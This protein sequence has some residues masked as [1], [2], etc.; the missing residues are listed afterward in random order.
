[1]EIRINEKGSEAFYDESV[2][3]MLQYRKLLKNPEKKLQDVQKQLK[4]YVIVCAVFELL[5]L[6]TGFAWGFDTLT[7]VAGALL[8][9]VILLSLTYLS[10]VTKAKKAM[11]SDTRTSVVTVDEQGVE[12][13]KQD[14]QVVRIGWDNVAFIRTFRE[15]VVV[16]SKDQTGILISVDRKYEEPFMQAVREYGPTVRLIG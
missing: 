5:L 13:N 10:T 6:G 4:V 2:N 3:V 12:L 14:S 7:I 15:S 9:F 16:F 11:L 1:M 8:S